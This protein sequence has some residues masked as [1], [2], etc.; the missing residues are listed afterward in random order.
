M[1]D[2]LLK[3]VDGGDSNDDAAR[4]AY[5]RRGLEKALDKIN[6]ADVADAARKLGGR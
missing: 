6:E 5:V 1:T 4:M 3:S 2:E